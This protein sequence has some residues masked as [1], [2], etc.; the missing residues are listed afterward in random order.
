MWS[1]LSSNATLKCVWVE[2]LIKSSAFPSIT[3]HRQYSLKLVTD[4][5]SFFHRRP[6]YMSSSG[7]G[8]PLLCR[9]QIPEI[10]RG[11][12]SVDHWDCRERKPHCSHHWQATDHRSGATGS[13]A[14]CQPNSWFC[15]LIVLLCCIID[16]K[17]EAPPSDFKHINYKTILAC[18]NIY[19]IVCTPKRLGWHVSTWK[20]ASRCSPRGTWF[21]GGLNHKIAKK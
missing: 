3:P 14:E 8:R 20:T 9:D 12:P 16:R 21:P 19:T 15:F 10:R 4:R 18:W 13:H 7:A 5:I 2:T 17:T 6:A 1:R 11:P